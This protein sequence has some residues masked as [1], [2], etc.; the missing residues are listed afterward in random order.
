[1]RGIDELMP[2]CNH[3]AR[4]GPRTSMGGRAQQVQTSCCTHFVF[5]LCKAGHASPAWTFSL[6]SLRF[7][8]AIIRGVVLAMVS[9]I[10]GHLHLGSSRSSQEQINRGKCL[11]LPTW[12]R[13]RISRPLENETSVS[14]R[15]IGRP[16]PS[17]PN[18]RL[19]RAR[20]HLQVLRS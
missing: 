6:I 19:N 18:Q 13:R 12:A 17:Q 15:G 9:A 4:Y 14:N 7:L 5:F 11:D 20:N 2:S 10:M 1:M 8:G 16:R 3:T